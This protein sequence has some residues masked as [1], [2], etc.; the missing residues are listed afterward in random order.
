MNIALW[1]IQGVLAA[2]FLIAGVLKATQP[3]EKLKANVLPWAEDVSDGTLRL[4]GIS[5]LLGALGLIL[6]WL[7]GIAPWLTPVAALGLT[8]IQVP[9]ILLHVRRKEPQVIVFNCALLAATLF[10]AVGRLAGSH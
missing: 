7:T 1:I 2:L 10:V 4:I 5:E 8:T 3:R 9:A 6:P